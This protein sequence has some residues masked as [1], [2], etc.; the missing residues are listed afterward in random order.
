MTADPPTRRGR[1]WLRWAAI[2]LLT[3]VAA[4]LALEALCRLLGYREMERFRTDPVLGFALH[5][6]QVVQDL[7]T[8]HPVRI[9]GLGLRGDAPPDAPVHWR[10]ACFG[11]SVTFGR[12]VLD[13]QAYPALLQTSLSSAHRDRSIDVRNLG[14]PGY[15]LVHARAW[16]EHDWAAFPAQVLIVA[17]TWNNHWLPGD[18]DA[19]AALADEIDGGLRVRNALKRTALFHWAMRSW[20]SLGLF[21]LY[22]AARD[23]VYGAQLPQAEALDAFEDNLDRIVELAAE[24]SAFVVLLRLPPDAGFDAAFLQ[25]GAALA[26]A[27]PDD[28]VVLD[29]GPAFDEAG[30]AEIWIAPF[31]PHPN[32]DGHRLIARAIEDVLIDREARELSR[33]PPEH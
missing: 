25:R 3:T 10:V 8:L 27:R 24:R 14:V 32:A 31:D 15:G 6:D 33:A 26:A 12:G 2:V 5:P 30:P 18:P 7:T 28:V 11:D 20:L 4:L 13:H 19:L 16:L 23:R 9:N 21:P 22:D 1:R 29:M 17:Q